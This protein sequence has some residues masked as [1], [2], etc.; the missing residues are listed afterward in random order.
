MTVF[1]ATAHQQTAANTSVK[2]APSSMLTDA[3]LIREAGF[4][5]VP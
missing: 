2:V 4:A 3:R 1:N 5:D